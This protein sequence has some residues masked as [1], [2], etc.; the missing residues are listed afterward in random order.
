M[1]SSEYLVRLYLF[2]ISAPPAAQTSQVVA[3]PSRAP[4]PKFMYLPNVHPPQPLLSCNHGSRVDRP[5]G[6]SW[7]TLIAKSSRVRPSVYSSSLARSLQPSSDHRRFH[8]RGPSWRPVPRRLPTP[9]S[10]SSL[11]NEEA[12]DGERCSIMASHATA[13]DDRVA[14]PT[15]IAAATAPAKP[16]R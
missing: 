3:L 6:N 4:P 8:C 16:V 10:F 13:V 14:T 11:C 7:T 5:R 15:A 2:R 1:T 12:A 9:L